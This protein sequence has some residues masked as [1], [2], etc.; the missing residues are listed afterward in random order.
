MR[1]KRD[2]P[3]KC[4]CKHYIALTSDWR[5]AN[6]LAPAPIFRADELDQFLPTNIACTSIYMQLYTPFLAWQI[7]IIGS[8]GTCTTPSTFP[9]ARRFVPV[10]PLCTP[11]PLRSFCDIPLYRA[12][13]VK[14]FPL[15][16]R[17][18]LTAW[19]KLL[20]YY[21]C[22]LFAYNNNVNNSEINLKKKKTGHFFQIFLIHSIVTML[23][24]LQ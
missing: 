12:F 20:L 7:W 10:T 3:C 19:R 23:L 6:A 1:G 14:V 21:Y 8:G 2:W 18:G 13:I 22:K 24:I 17:R 11:L 4:S 5:F 15:T 16:S 9:I